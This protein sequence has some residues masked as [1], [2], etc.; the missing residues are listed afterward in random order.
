M[1][2]DLIIIKIAWFRHF[3]G[4]SKKNPFLQIFPNGVFDHVR[5][6]LQM[7]ACM[8]TQVSNY[9]DLCNRRSQQSL[10]ISTPCLLVCAWVASL[11]KKW[12]LFASKPFQH[13]FTHG[14]R[15][16]ICLYINSIVVFF[17][18]AY[19][20]FFACCTFLLG[21]HFVSF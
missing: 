11:T 10:K 16:L 1:C 2:E 21:L 18:V 19:L 20:I 3:W 12:L 4:F 17:V 9:S 6:F 14:T 5:K 8:L 13:S 7:C 15:S